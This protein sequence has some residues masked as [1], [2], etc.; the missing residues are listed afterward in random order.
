VDDLPGITAQL[1]SAVKDRFDV[2]AFDPP[3]VGHSTEVTC[4]NSAGL[5]AYFHVDP[6]PTT[7][8]G[9]S[10]LL[11]ADRTFANG[12]EAR[13][14]AVL[15][16]VSTVDAARAMDE[17]RQALGDPKLTYLGFSYGTFLG[18]TYAELYPDRVRA[19][20]LDG[21][22]D[23]TLDT[24]S[25]VRQQTAAL[26]AQLQQFF[27]GCRADPTCAWQPGSNPAAT[28]Q[29]L[30][31]RVRNR[32]LPVSASSRTVG[33]AELLYGT[34]AALY[35]TETWPNLASA[36]EQADGGNGTQM[37]A[38]FDNYTGR[39][40]D[41]SYNNLFEA[42]AAVTCLDSPSPSLAQLQ[43]AAPAIEATAPVFGVQDLYS[44][45]GCTVWPIQ[46]TGTAHAIHAV[47]A[48]PILVVGST[49]DPITPYPW[50]ES[51]AHQ[52]ARGVLLTRVGDGHT[53]YGA[54]ACIRSK[55]DAYLINLKV[56]PPGTRCAS[57]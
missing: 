27:T 13:S 40:P 4:L 44:F 38:L 30:L 48:P 29:I 23:P 16:Y 45:A 33:P 56:P 42:N 24:I 9:F 11:D 21:A 18:A 47:G 20:V 14:G 31:R 1:G 32:P 57:D 19:L 26:D 50:A 25:L 5:G 15:P 49:G 43:A 22:L 36:L 7:A 28:Y 2:V 51:L 39:S 3:G 8:S 35:T 6:A 52:L 53:A 41:G 54:S 46:P 37:L 10:A 12:C 34:A 17:V 55:A